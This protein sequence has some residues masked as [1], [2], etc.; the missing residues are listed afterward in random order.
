MATA[1]RAGRRL[2][3]SSS[4]GVNDTGG[5]VEKDHG[6]PRLVARSRCIRRRRVGYAFFFSPVRRDLHRAHRAGAGPPGLVAALHDDRPRRGSCRARRCPRCPAGDL[7]QFRTAST[8]GAVWLKPRRR[9]P[10]S[11][12]VCVCV[13]VSSVSAVCVGHGSTRQRYALADGNKFA[14]KDVSGAQKVGGDHDEDPHG[15]AAAVAALERASPRRRLKSSASLGA[16]RS[17]MSSRVRCVRGAAPGLHEII[18]SDRGQPRRAA[19]R[20][21]GLLARA[22]ATREA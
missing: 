13:C 1:S 2:P 17:Y 8:A 11:R 19:P 12:S 4:F 18:R 15:G 9:S 6:L 7:P 20:G 16:A 5:A 21:R 22:P 3:A 14:F 10:T